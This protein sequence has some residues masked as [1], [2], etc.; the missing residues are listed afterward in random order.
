MG[1]RGEGGEMCVDKGKIWVGLA[2]V[3]EA[4]REGKGLY[5][6]LEKESHRDLQFI[7]LDYPR[8]T[9]EI[10]EERRKKIKRIVIAYLNGE[11]EGGYTSAMM[12]IV[13][14]LEEYVEEE[15]NCFW[16]FRLIMNKYHWNSMM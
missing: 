6:R 15:E 5:Y 2:G 16:V 4:K 3:E 7:E 1:N 10:E 8:L 12:I 13:K 9:Y 14:F 11:E